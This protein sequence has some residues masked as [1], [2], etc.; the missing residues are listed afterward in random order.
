MQQK[1]IDLYLKRSYKKKNGFFSRVCGYRTMEN[2][3]KLNEGRVRLDI[4]KKI[5]CVVAL[6]QVVQKCGGC[7]VPGD[8]QGEAG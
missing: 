6:Q 5:F 3:F 2:G 8:F 1:I 4:R 7:P